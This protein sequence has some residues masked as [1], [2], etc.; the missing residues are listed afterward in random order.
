MIG[1][2]ASSLGEG[3]LASANLRLC[4]ATNQTRDQAEL[5]RVVERVVQGD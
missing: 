1:R 3:L 4:G 5:R 2:M